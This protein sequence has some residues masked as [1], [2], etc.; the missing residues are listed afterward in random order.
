MTKTTSIL[1]LAVTLLIG[2]CT[3]NP[4][5]V[6]RGAAAECES[7][8][9]S[10]VPSGER[11]CVY[12]P[13]IVIETGFR[14]PMHLANRLDFRNFSVCSDRTKLPVLDVE[15][16]HRHFDVPSREPWNLGQDVASN[17]DV[18]WVI[19]N[20]GSFCQ[21]QKEIREGFAAFAETL[22]EE[23]I[24][25]HIAVTTT[26]T[27]EWDLDPVASPGQFQSTPQPLPGFDPSCRY[28]LDAYGEVIPGD[29]QPVRD[30]IELAVSCMKEPAYNQYAFSDLEIE[31]AL[32]RLPDCQ[33]KNKTCDG[34]CDVTDLFP[35]TD[36]YRDI[37]KVLRA[38]DYRTDRG[39]LDVDRLRADF[40]CMSMVGSRGY[41]FEKGLEA[42]VMAMSPEMTG[43]STE[44]AML[45]SA[46]NH[47][48]LR[49]EARLAVMFASDENDCSHDGSL[50]ER[51]VCGPSMCDYAASP[52]WEGPSPLIPVE[53]LRRRLIENVSASKLREVSASEIYVG[54]VVGR[55]DP[56]TGPVPD[57]MLCTND[58][59]R[60]ASTTC[61]SSRGTVSSGDRYDSFARS[62]PLS[63]VFP[64]PDLYAPDTPTEGLLC[65]SE[66]LD[67]W[68][69]QLGEFLAH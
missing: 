58:H 54:N 7:G 4:V 22:G 18:L 48:F 33:F 45:R 68:M 8:E 13:E 41:G 17:V 24:D 62:F 1:L 61:R 21:E 43:G 57:E 37:P 56:Y 23:Q 6:Q 65:S 19:D 59:A 39:G 14:C 42:A 11:V 49:D 46:P 12:R 34:N 50:N 47:G 60:T 3:E 15:F 55:S 16:L 67:F 38:S 51:S 66:P 20:S 44:V 40:A 69:L 52:E 30:A 31:C 5:S 32:D 2:A 27:D 63:N 53:T 35:T 64:K 26:Q 29:Y 10:T 36:E 9:S 28:A 25:F